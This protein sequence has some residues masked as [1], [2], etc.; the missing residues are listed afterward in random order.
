MPS[1]SFPGR[2]LSTSAAGLIALLLVLPGSAGASRRSPAAPGSTPW[3]VGD[4]IPPGVDTH[5]QTLTEQWDGSA[6]SVVPSPN[7]GDTKKPNVLHDVDTLGD[8]TTLA[9][10][11]YSAPNQAV[12]QTLAEE[13]C[14]N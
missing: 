2:L 7:V 6:W 11:Y 1:S 14:P 13:I 4:Y 3:A 9:V 10:G 8:G 5:L 12:F